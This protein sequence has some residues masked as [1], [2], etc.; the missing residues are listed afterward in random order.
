MAGWTRA[1]MGDAMLHAL[2]HDVDG[3][4]S[5]PEAISTQVRDTTMYYRVLAAHEQ[6]LASDLMAENFPARTGLA[7]VQRG[8]AGASTGRPSACAESRSRLS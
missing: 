6:R 4:P 3:G 7:A 1:Q 5:D 2:A 8:Q